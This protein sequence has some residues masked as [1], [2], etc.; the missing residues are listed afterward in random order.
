M[1]Q[2]RVFAGVLR[3]ARVKGSEWLR[4]CG[5]GLAGGFVHGRSWCSEVVTGP[6]GLTSNPSYAEEMYLSW[7]EDH[8]SVHKVMRGPFHPLPSQSFIQLESISCGK[9]RLLVLLQVKFMNC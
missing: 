3:G 1:S 4:A 2:F 7:L 6:S 8:E 9:C 5:A